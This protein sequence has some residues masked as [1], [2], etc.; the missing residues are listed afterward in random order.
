MDQTDL[1]DQFGN[2]MGPELESD[3][4]DDEQQNGYRQELANVDQTS[5]MEDDGDEAGGEDEAIDVSNL[6]TAVVLHEDKKYYPSAIEV[7]GPDVETV[8]QEEDTQALTEP[9]IAP[10]K[11]AKFSLVE[12][13]IPETIYD[14]EYLADLMDSPELVRNVAMCGQLHHG[15]TT[16][17]DA[18][19]EQTHPY[20]ASTENKELRY[21][22]TLFTEQERGV[23]IKS[24]PFTILLPDLKDKNFLFNIL[25]TPG[26]VNFSDEV[27]AAFR[28]CD[29]V[30]IFVDAHE[31]VMLNTDRLIKHAMQERLAI[32]LCINKIDRLVLELKLPPQDAFFKIKHIIDEVNGLIKTHSEDESNA[33]Y[34]SPLLNNVCFA[35]SYYRFCFTLK[36]FAKVYA[37]TH[38]NAFD[39]QALAKRL[40]GDIYYNAKTRTFGK[41]GATASSSRSF[42]QFILEPL[43][44]IL[45]HVVGDVDITLPG[46][47]DE[48]GIRLS[49]TELKLN[50]RPLLRLVCARFFGE[51]K[52]FADMI[53]Q[54]IPSPVANA[55][56]KIEHLYTGSLQEDIVTDMNNC[57]PDAPVIIHTTKNYST[58]DATSFHV[59][60][61][62]FCGTLKSGQDV[63]I[64]GENY[65]LKDPEDSFSCAVGR[66]WVFNA[67]YRIELNRVPVGNWVLIEGVDQ[68]IV[69]TSTIVDNSGLIRGRRMN[70]TNIDDVQ[71]FRPLKFNT[72]SVIKIAV[73]PV[74][75][76]ELPKMLDGLRKVNKSYPLLNTKV[77]ESG[78]HII[79]GTGELYLD[80]V[81]HDLRR[82]YSEIEIK[83]ADP[84]VT[85]CETV[86]ET[87][88]LKCFAETPNKK[89]KLTMIAEPLEKGIAEDI[90]QE[91]VQI[92]WNNKRISDFFQN[93]YEWDI[94]A[95]RSIWA[96]GP[97]INGPNILLD[98]TLSHE[99][100]KTLLTSEPVKESIVQGFQWATREGPLCDEPIRNVKF[101]ILDASIAQEPI[102]HGRGQLIP[103]ARRVA[104]SSFL[105][106]TPRLME[107]YYFVEVI[108]PADCVS[109]VYTVL[110]RRRG[111]VT[112]DAPVP[113]S[114]LYTLKA[115]I[116]AIDSMGFETD[117]RTHTQ[118][119][120]FCMSV[121]HHWQIV[122]GDPLDKSIVIRPLEAQP[123]N[124]LARE[125]MIKTRRR[126]GLSEDV[127]INKFF[128]DP[129][130]LE[131]A[132]QDVLL[133]YPI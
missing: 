104:Y 7:Y 129:M 93:R 99:V 40:W 37:D 60:G 58:S 39:Y 45:A 67:R 95:S 109:A 79:L 84:V 78:E 21:T 51:F 24:T 18:L 120:A 81:M 57:N 41:K 69:K 65:S 2:Y 59:L 76:S 85:F 8:V 10:V 112:L 16:F 105:L 74:N 19:I 96:F 3:E 49:K 9:V 52:G 42:V 13:E 32:T 98:D 113:G 66:L 130:L 122:P 27:T 103:T 17:C 91:V 50:I 73:E 97:D 25:D 87:S 82:M 128:D 89:N 15:K 132:R 5:D 127:S 55:R 126:K 1:Y 117:L 44:K 86:V 6:S 88:S 123:V 36:S 34:V 119:Q 102:H 77:E 63:R 106:A 26:H 61:R 62:I 114:P 47:I 108:A 31:G 116:P 46:V 121:F 107:P 133:N 92:S 118:G 23:S 14:L 72:T 56:N 125:F 110:G 11:K 94:L 131:L 22:D 35:S 12:Q 30:V 48:L 100:N 68:S 90:E 124:H 4:E 28:L 54:H 83:V 20:L 71:I 111:H 33:S 70:V 101:K 43:Y 64:L 53:V 75:P 115:F 29:G 38:G 80:C